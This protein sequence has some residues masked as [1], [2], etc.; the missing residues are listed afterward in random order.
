[1]ETYAPQYW[2]P[3]W[4][5]CSNRELRAN[6]IYRQLRYDPNSWVFINPWGAGD[7]Y[8]M[9]SLMGDFIKYHCTNNERIV[10]LVRKQYEEIPFMFSQFSDRLTTISVPQEYMDAT[11]Q[12]FG[13]QQTFTKGD[14]ILFVP[15]HWGQGNLQRIFFLR[16]ISATEIFKFMLHVPFDATLAKP[17]LPEAFVARAEAKLR[18]SFDPAQKS[19]LLSPSSV[20]LKP[21]PTAFWTMIAQHL[22]EMGYRVFSDTANGR[23]PPI[24]GTIDLRFTFGEAVPVANAIGRVICHQTGLAYVLSYS[25]CKMTSLYLGPLPSPLYHAPFSA[26][27]L[28]N[29]GFKDDEE[30]IEIPDSAS[31]EEAVEFAMA[32]LRPA[33]A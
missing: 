3:L 14:P 9:V 33:Y 20:T 29:N 5:H 11:V 32:A 22:K 12:D 26:I 18:Q 7:I 24:E 21:F 10:L 2:M 31:V 23:I 13:L 17:I 28:K 8:P 16:G 4:G 30:T 25:A 1:M 19:V 15:T 6:D 27:S